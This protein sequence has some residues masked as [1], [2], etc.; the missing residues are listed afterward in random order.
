VTRRL[1]ADMRKMKMRALEA[2]PVTRHELGIATKSARITYIR[3]EDRVVTSKPM[4][5]N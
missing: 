3:V 1:K 4:C 2:L 5:Q